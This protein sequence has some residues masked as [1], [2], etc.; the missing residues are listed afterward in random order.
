LKEEDYTEAECQQMA[1][2]IA[3]GVLEACMEYEL[4][5]VKRKFEY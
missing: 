3:W 5:E 4:L 2:G 1:H